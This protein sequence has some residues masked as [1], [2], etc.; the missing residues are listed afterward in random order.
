MTDDTVRQS[1]RECAIRVHQSEI[2]TGTLHYGEAGGAIIAAHVAETVA[3]WREIV[4]RAVDTC[5][6]DR[7]LRDAR[8]LLAAS[9]SGKDDTNA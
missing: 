5:I 3:P 1:D 7:W 2:V 4:G 6:D 8:A 9:E